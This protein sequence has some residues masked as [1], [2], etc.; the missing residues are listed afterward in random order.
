MI[1]IVFDS[2]DSESQS[3]I[4][5]MQHTSTCL[6]NYHVEDGYEI[7]PNIFHF[8]QVLI[9]VSKTDHYNYNNKRY[10]QCLKSCT[11]YCSIK[12][13]LTPIADL[14]VHGILQNNKPSGKE[15]L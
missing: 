7:N 15:P 9:G 14:H 10:W 2:K 6:L 4:N 11:E 13:D 3:T 8:I 12:S 1:K 5:V